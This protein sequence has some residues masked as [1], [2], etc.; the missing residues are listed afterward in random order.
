[1]NRLK[2]LI[3]VLN[4]VLFQSAGFSQKILSAIT[5]GDLEYVTKWLNKGEDIDIEFTKTSETGLE[6]EF[7]VISWAAIKNQQEIVRFFVANK[8]KFDGYEIFIS[9]A[10]GASVQYGDLSFIQFLISEG[11]DVNVGCQYCKDVSPIAVALAY[12]YYDVYDYFKRIGASEN[13]SGGDYELIHAAASQDS[14]ELLKAILAK[15]SDNLYLKDV[16]GYTPFLFAVSKK[17]IDNAEYLISEGADVA[18]MT[19]EGIGLLHVAALTG[20]TAVYRWAEN[21]YHSRE[22]IVDVMSLSVFAFAIMADNKDLF[23]YFMENYLI[24]EFMQ[25]YVIGDDYVKDGEVESVTFAFLEVEKNTAYFFEK[26]NALGFDWNF[27]DQEYGKTLKQY[28]KW[29]NKK[30]LYKLLKEVG[31]E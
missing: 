8:S 13:F 14:L 23:D 1:M 9:R 27:E 3:I 22:L 20:D 21:V 11:A 29:Q 6:N 26:L 16:D 7:D 17:L 18:V 2:L 31:A 12:G 24:G 15:Q 19:H 30:E 25:D 4:V 28:A 10:L 5:E